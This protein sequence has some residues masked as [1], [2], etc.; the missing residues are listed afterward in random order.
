MDAV[1]EKLG[2]YELFSIFFAGSV[3]TYSSL[4]FNDRYFHINVFLSSNGLNNT[5]LF[6]LISCFVGFLFQELGS[7]A[8]KYIIFR[9][10]GL[11]KEAYSKEKTGVNHLSTPE[12]EKLEA[13]FKKNN[14]TD[15]EEK[16]NTCKY[17]IINN[18]NTSK[19]DKDLALS[20]MSRSFFIYFLIIS[21]LLLIY[22]IANMDESIVLPFAL[23]VFVSILMFLRQK[24]FAIM[25]YVSIFR[26][27]LYD[28]NDKQ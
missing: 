2:V 22:M 10:K 27:Y 23:S 19:I 15:L 3:I 18:R 9:G 6:I 20:S 26:T 7:I 17:Y 24:R 8:N 11:L 21:L 16:Y 25:R 28:H 5:F 13:L 12:F 1:F 4:M 14:I